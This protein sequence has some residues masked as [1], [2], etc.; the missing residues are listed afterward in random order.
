LIDARRD[1]GDGATA[2]ARFAVQR[3][4]FEGVDVE[5]W[6]PMQT[7]WRDAALAGASITL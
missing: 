3:L 5:R 1:P 7:L 4:R 2:P 6:A